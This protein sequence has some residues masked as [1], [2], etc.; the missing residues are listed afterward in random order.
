MRWLGEN[1]RD[2]RAAHHYTLEQF[3]L[4]EAG[5]EKDFQAYR[6]RFIL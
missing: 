4:S 5:L 6:E 2:K 1:A 3:G